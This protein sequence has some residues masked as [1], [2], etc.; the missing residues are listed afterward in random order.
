MVEGN[1][2]VTVLR[3]REAILR[4]PRNATISPPLPSL[5]ITRPMLPE[6]GSRRLPSGSINPNARPVRAASG[7]GVSSA[8][9]TPHA[10]ARG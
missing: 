10:A 5:K 2:D 4:T 1:R 8:Y 7:R 3:T 6:R 9:K